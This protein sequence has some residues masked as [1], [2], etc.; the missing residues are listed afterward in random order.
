MLVQPSSGRG[1]HL[2]PESVDLFESDL[3]YVP[4]TIAHPAHHESRNSQARIGGSRYPG[5]QKETVDCQNADRL[6]AV[7]QLPSLAIAD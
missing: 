2:A 5:E 4:S 3:L 1:M 7:T 6:P